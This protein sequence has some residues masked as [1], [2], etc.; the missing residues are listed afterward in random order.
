MDMDGV[1]FWNLGR[2][3][4]ALA[5]LWVGIAGCDT[6]GCAGDDG[7]TVDVGLAYELEIDEAVDHQSYAAGLR[8][9]DDIGDRDTDGQMMIHR[10]EGEKAAELRL[11]RSEDLGVVDEA[12]GEMSELEV[13]DRDAQVLRLQLTDRA[14]NQLRDQAMEAVIPSLRARLEDEGFDDFQLLRT[15]DPGVQLQISN[16]DRSEFPRLKASVEDRRELR[17]PRV[18]MEKSEAFFEQFDGELPDG[19]EMRPFIGDTDTV[20][21][22]DRDAL[23]EFFAGRV[24]EGYRIGYEYEPKQE[25]EER[26]GPDSDS[27][28]LDDEMFEDFGPVPAHWKSI[29]VKED[30]PIEGRHLMEVFVDVDERFNRPVVGLRFDEVG[31]KALADFTSE[32]IGNTVAIMAGDQIFST[33]RIQEP[34]TEG[35][36][37][38]NLSDLASHTE[39]QDEAS[40]LVVQLRA[41]IVPYSLE[42]SDEVVE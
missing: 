10:R 33:P 6:G 19:F 15:A 13:V 7:E 28:L 3:S 12:I 18:D 39:V 25:G 29:L 36:L 5:L 38:M 22:P 17:F 16:L 35:D 41:L 37:R 14:V 32:N 4:I 23:R 11:S 26:S 40:E 31:T 9:V 42:L 1:K 24:P 20:T 21:H 27:P 34:I 30:S 8:L 2:W